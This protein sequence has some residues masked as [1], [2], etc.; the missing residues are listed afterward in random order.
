MKSPTAPAR[1][2]L[3][4]VACMVAITLAGIG[5]SENQATTTSNTPV[6]LPDINDGLEIA[7]PEDRT[8]PQ[9]PVRQLAIEDQQRRFV[10]QPGY[11]IENVLAE[12]H[13]AEP[14]AIA[15][16]GNGRMFVLELRSYMLDLEATGELDPTSRISMHEDTNNDGIYDRHTVFVDSLV[17]A[18]FVMPFGANSILTMES[19]EDEVYQFTDTDGDG[20]ADEKKLFTT[21]YGRAGNVE[22]QQAFLYWGMDNWLYSTYNAFRIRWTPDGTILR[23]PTGPNGAQWGVTQD[24]E[25]KIWFQGGASGVPS[26]FQFPIVYG[27]YTVENQLEEGFEIPYGLAGLGDFQPGADASRPDGTL[28]RVTGSAGNDVYRGHRMPEDLVG[29]YLYGEP[30]A[31]I[32]RRIRPVVTEGITQLQ[33]VYQD[34]EAEF[35]RSTDPLFRPVD[36]ATAPDGSIYIVD[37]YR[38]IIQEGQW[39]PPESFLRDKI[40]QYNLDEAIGHGRIWRLTHEN[41]PRDREQ[42]RM[43]D[44]TPAQLIRHLKHPNGWWRDTAQQLLVL[45]QDRSVVPALERMARGS[46]NFFTRLFGR[47]DNLLARYHAL[48]TLE[49]LGALDADLVREQMADENPRMRVMAIR[50]SET[51]Y[52]N[53]DLSFADD[54]IALAADEDADV[55]IQAMMTLNTLNVAGAEEAIQ[56]TVAG[57]QARGVQEIGTRI[58]T[59]PERRWPRFVGVEQALYD[60][61]ATIYNELCTECHGPS[62]QGTPFSPGQTLAPALAASERVQGHRDYIVKTLL[63]GLTGDIDGKTYPGQLMVSMGEHPDEWV[64][65]VSSYVRNSFT[66]SAPMITAEEVAQIRAANTDRT[67]AWT[68]DEL[69]ASIPQRTSPEESWVVTSSHDNERAFG[70]L[71]FEGWRTEASQERGMWFQVEIPA[72]INLAEIQFE[73]RW[74]RRGRGPDAPPPQLTA[75]LRYRVEVSTDGNTWRNVAEGEGEKTT[76]VISFPPVQARFVRIT[77]TANPGDDAPYWSMQQLRFYELP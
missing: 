51:L 18:R 33:N 70:A 9:T 62:G 6:A 40:L 34:Q 74:R 41:M 52:K 27:N 57:N 36:M 30:V 2:R 66:N 64:A 8:T 31:R 53:G 24:N 7:P 59:P 37:M 20:V 29:D 14:A 5:C 17:F 58:L 10:L 65:A 42:P 69:M 15:F 56:E 23:E 39:T 61:G 67:T 26:Y 38:G 77:Q 21:N 32:V 13:V 11:Q 43:L 4:F 22:H 47:P 35:I 54:Y 19:N 3:L 76:T 75:P 1:H 60:R 68:Y 25:G 28:N 49:G 44:E 73:S 55:A 50:L 72:A 45:S 46:G 63:H 12:P 16:D 71:N 48:W